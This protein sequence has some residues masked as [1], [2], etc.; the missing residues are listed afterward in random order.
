VR[1]RNFYSLIRICWIALF[2]LTASLPLAAETKKQVLIIDIPRLV[3]EDINDTPNLNGFLAGGAVGL[4]TVPVEPLTFEKVYLGFNSGTQLRTPSQDGLLIFNATEEYRHLPA[5]ELYQA[6]TGYRTGDQ[7]GVHLGLA[8]IIQLNTGSAFRNVGRFGWLLHQNSLRTAAIGNADAE[9]PNRSGAL[10]LMDE[11]GRIDLAALGKETLKRD[12]GFPFEQVSDED[13]IFAYWLKF[14]KEAD[15][16]VITLGDFERLE[17]FA[18]YLNEE[19]WG[20]YRRTIIERYDRLLGRLQATID[21]DSTLTM[22]FTGVGSQRITKTEN[23]LMPVAIAMPGLAPGIIYSPSTRKPGVISLYDLPATIFKFLGIKKSGRFNGQNLRSIP[24][25]WQRVASVRPE[26]IRNYQ[27]RWP[28]LTIYAYLLIGSILA[29]VIGSIYK[30]RPFVFKALT[31]TYLGLVMVPAVFLIMA[32]FNPLNWLAIIGLTLGLIALMMLTAIWL[33]G[34][35]PFRILSLISLA[36]MIIIIIDG[37]GNGF[38]EAKSFL[39]YSVVA[40]ARFYG[41]GNEYLGF[42]LGAYTVFL[43][44]NLQ[45]FTKYKYGETVLWPASWMI[46][47]LVAHPGLGAN[48][49]GGST[50]ILGLGITNHLLLK[51]KINLKGIIKLCS[52]LLVLLTLVGAWDIFIN[53]D[54]MAHFG[55]MLLLIKDEG[56]QVVREMISRKWEMNLRLIDYT[57]WSKALLGILILVPLLYYK[58]SQKIIELLRKHP[59]PLRGFLGLIF[60]AFIALIVN[61]SGIVTVATMLLFGGV[62]LLLVFFEELDKR[63]V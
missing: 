29:G 54:N 46:A 56:F 5:G 47:L 53:K 6:L 16:I 31:Y 43:A 51:K 63:G 32:A 8:K 9:Q 20:F 50:A 58:P 57:P 33:K 36:T 52:A 23:K 4:V 28:L 41:I 62:L 10:L 1:I 60:T 25:D 15:V 55:Q 61:D 38:L 30:W 11:K 35:D 39:G 18:P 42:L 7:G 21:H 37:L 19:R 49:G 59:E 40:G 17:R 2:L 13:Q 26:L 27:V 24:G 3:F 45:D 12:P 48:I 34:I 22:L 44:L 14:K